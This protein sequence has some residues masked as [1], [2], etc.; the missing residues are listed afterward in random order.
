MDV[1]GR[2]MTVLNKVTGLPVRMTSEGDRQYFA[3]NLRVVD[4][5][6]SINADFAPKVCQRELQNYQTDQAAKTGIKNSKRFSTQPWNFSS[7]VC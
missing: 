7:R 5:N 1:V 2:V 3:G 6:I 4:N